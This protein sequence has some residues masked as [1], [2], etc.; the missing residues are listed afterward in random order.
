MNKKFII[1]FL[2][3]FY[4][5]V[6]QKIFTLYLFPTT[7]FNIVLSQLNQEVLPYEIIIKITMLLIALSTLV[8][9]VVLK[10]NL[11]TGLSPIPP[12]MFIIMILIFSAVIPAAALLNILLT[13]DILFSSMLL[14]YGVIFTSVVY[15]KDNENTP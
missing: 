12:E 9:F 11:R 4:L 14:I 15:I 1:V 2:V 8:A 3:F 7:D 5:L 13:G 6:I 10:N